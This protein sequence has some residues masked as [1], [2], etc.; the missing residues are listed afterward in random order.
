M[1]THTVAHANATSRPDTSRRTIAYAMAV[2]TAATR[3][4]VNHTPPKAEEASVGGEFHC[5]IPNGAHGPPNAGKER[6]TSAATHALGSTSKAVTEGPD[7]SRC[8]LH[9]HG[10]H[11]APN[12][13]AITIS[14]GPMLVVSQ[15]WVVST[16]P[17]RPHHARTAPSQDV[18]AVRTSRSSGTK[19]TQ[20]SHHHETVGKASAGSDPTT[21]AA[22]QP[23]ARRRHAAL[24]A[25]PTRMPP[26]FANG[27]RKRTL[28]EPH[29]CAT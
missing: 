19:P 4:L 11:S 13:A 21:K 24:K 12:P 15:Y 28:N 25:M 23:G 1:A 7:K 8:A 26:A 2:L 3:K 27:D 29:L 9:P 14:S 16:N 22:S 5:D 6:T 10:S 20:P 18:G 17:V